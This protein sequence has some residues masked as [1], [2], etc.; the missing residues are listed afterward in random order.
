L[1]IVSILTKL[2]E[3][4]SGVPKMEIGYFTSPDPFC[5]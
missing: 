2:T 5:E 3:P 4:Y 1:A